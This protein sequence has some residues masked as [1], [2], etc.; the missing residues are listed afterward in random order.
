MRKR[1]K[2]KNYEQANI[3]LEQSYL[4]SKGLLK[5]ENTSLMEDMQKTITT[6]SG[7]DAKEKTVTQ[8][9]LTLNSYAKKLYALFKKEGAKVLLS[10]TGFKNVGDMKGNQVGIDTAT[11]KG[12]GMKITIN[13][14]GK[15]MDMAN[16]YGPLILKT[17]PDLE[18]EGKPKEVSGWEGVEAVDFILKPKK[19]VNLT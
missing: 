5:E 11:T 9:N 15:S 18:L 4:K 10:S 3:M 17:F 2:L 12:E 19:G 16:K 7:W 14:G 1:D 6:G 13:M 8:G